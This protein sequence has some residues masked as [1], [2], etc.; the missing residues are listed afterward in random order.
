MMKAKKLLVLAGSILAASTLAGCGGSSGDDGTIKITFDHTFGEGIEKGVQAQ[1]EKFKK[2]VEAH[3]NVKLELIMPPAMTYKA[4]V[5]T[6]GMELTTGGPTMTVAYPDHVASLQA[7]EGTPG[8]WIVNMDPYMDSDEVGFGKES[9]LGERTAWDK[10]DIIPTYL[11]EGQE[12]SVEGTYCLPF[13]KSTEILQY[14][15]DVVLQALS[16]YD[17]TKEMDATG[18]QEF[19][20]TMSFAQMMDIA[21]IIKDH[22]D[23]FGC[24][25][26]ETPVFYDSDSNMAITQFIQSG[27]TYSDF[28]NG[29]PV[30]GLDASES[31]M[32]ENV[33]KV[34]EVLSQIRTWAQDGLL[35]TKAAYGNYSSTSFKQQ[36]CIFIVG[37]SGGAGYSVPDEGDFNTGYA[38]VPYVGDEANHPEYV[39]QGPSIAFLRDTS[40]SN[41][42]N[43]LRLK[44]AWKFYKY[45]IM[46]NTNVALTVNDSQGY[47][48]IRKSAYATPA[49]GKVISPDTEAGEEITYFTHT[50]NIVQSIDYH[51]Y[52]TKV[53]KGSDKYRDNVTTL[54]KDVIKTND[55][56]DSLLA[57]CIRETKKYM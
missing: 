2:I 28:K 25:D 21:Q 17:V 34:K 16:I 56:L 47:V 6:V 12:F 51:F 31:S 4:V 14:N 26:L 50:A 53:F 55:D 44:Y 9:W 48:P 1:F 23:E 24:P 32:A 29:Q 22:K 36:K 5:D 33:T 13:M 42:V 40:V 27:L 18:K 35:T 41:E 20:S 45:L 49:W 19:L 7:R 37:S 46:P 38:R 10:N 8:R 54:V 11:R 52:N 3:D 43:E 30:L 57:T 39:S 15:A